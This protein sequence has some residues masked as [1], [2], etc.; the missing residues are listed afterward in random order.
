MARN[1]PVMVVRK[2]AHRFWQRPV[3]SYLGSRKSVSKRVVHLLGDKRKEAEK[4]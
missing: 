4:Q 2:E 1:N 3:I